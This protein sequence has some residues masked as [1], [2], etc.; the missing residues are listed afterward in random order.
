MA[1]R[2]VRG[3]QKRDVSDPIAKS[4]LQ[5]IATDIGHDDQPAYP[6]YR[7]IAE[8]AGCHFNT[9]GDKV[10]ELEEEGHLAVEKK[11]RRNY[12]NLPFNC[13]SNV[14]PSSQAEGDKK[15]GLVTPYV[16][17]EGELLQRID[18]LCDK[19]ESLSQEVS[20]LSQ[21]LSHFVTPRDV[22]EVEDISTNTPPN[23]PRGANGGVVWVKALDEDAA[24]VI[25]HLKNEVGLDV[26][27]QRDA[28]D[29]WEWLKDVNKLLGLGGGVQGTCDL[30]DRVR[31]YM[32]ENDLTYTRPGSFVKIAR[33]M[34]A[35]P[36]PDAELKQEA[37]EQWH[38][39]MRKA[40][41]VG[42]QRWREWGMSDKTRD[43]LRASL[44]KDC[45]AMVTG[46]KPE[47]YKERFVDEYVKQ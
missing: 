47:R 5:V 41:S 26:P 22:T 27:R 45:L 21:R 11:G 38:F 16:T 37:E 2:H 3:A 31:A 20:I 19:V 10:R 28:E 7:T 42:R 40:E 32:D 4:I 44:G 46:Y 43:T 1:L 8:R 9:V 35:A 25:R 34:A 18:I 24:D 14:T 39:I 23:P 13:N 33:R 15:N 6:S 36:G 17:T 29:G 30:I 12:Y